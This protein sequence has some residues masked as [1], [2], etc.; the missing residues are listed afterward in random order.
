M[1]SSLS[2]TVPGRGSEGFNKHE[3]AW[4]VAAVQ[5]ERKPVLGESVGANKMGNR[6]TKVKPE[7]QQPTTEHSQPPPT[8]E[9]PESPSIEEQSSDS[10]LS[11]ALTLARDRLFISHALDSI[12]KLIGDVSISFQ[13]FFD[14]KQCITYRGRRFYQKP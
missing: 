6:G 7:P 13:H 2:Q 8:W 14:E 10:D 9:Q 5:H 1:I 4:G 3:Q 12:V 11:D